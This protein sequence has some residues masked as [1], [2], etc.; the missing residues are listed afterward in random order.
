MPCALIS[1]TSTSPRPIKEMLELI[2]LSPL[3]TARASDLIHSSVQ[4]DP[5]SIEG[6][7]FK[8]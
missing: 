5:E 4:R 1:P 2:G 3:A 6:H 7:C 8:R